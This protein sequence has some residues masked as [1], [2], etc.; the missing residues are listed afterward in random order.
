MLEPCR[1]RVQNPENRM[2][3]TLGTGSL[4]LPLPAQ[5]VMGEVQEGRGLIWNHM[6]PEG[7]G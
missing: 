5:R 3:P 2:G 7:Q 6:G 1:A 4:P